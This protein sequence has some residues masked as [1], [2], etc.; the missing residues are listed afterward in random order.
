MTVVDDIKERVDIVEIVG[1][2]VKLRK[3]GKNYVGFCPFHQNT[4][5]P[6]F[7]VFPDTGTWR[8]FGACNEG[9]DVYSFLMKKEGWDFKETLS[10]LA[11]R[12]GI[13]LTPLSP[14]QEA[15]QEAHERL[16]E[17]L[18]AAVVYYRQQLLDSDAGRQVQ[19]YLKGRNLQKP[20]L[21]TFEIGY[22]PDSFELTGRYLSSRGFTEAELEEAGLLS[23]RDSGGTYDR[24]RHRIM[25]PIR[26]SRGRMVGFGARAVDKDAVPKY[27]NSPQTPIFDKSR[28][29]YGLD[30][31]RKA[32]RSENLAV[33]VEG[34]MDVIG[35]H[36][37]GFENLVSPM[38]VALSEHQLRML[39]R[40]SRRMVLALDPDAAGIQGALRGLSVARE[41]LDRELDPVFDARGLLRYEGRLD[42]DI[43][44]VTLPEELDPDEV[45]AQDP[46]EWRRLIDEAKT[47]VDFMMDTLAMEYDLHDPKA[48]G[49]V[50]SRILPLIADVA[51][52]VERDAYRQKLA[53]LLQ[54]DERTLYSQRA[55]GKEKR[56]ARAIL[57]QP[58]GLVSQEDAA[59][60]RFSLGVL[61]QKPEFL[62][63]VDRLF[64]EA[65]LPRLSDEDFQSTARREMFTIIRQSL[66][67]DDMEPGSFW[68]HRLEGAMLELAQTVEA[69]AGDVDFS[70][71]RTRSEILSGF[72]HMRKRRLDARL[73]ELHFQQALA[74]EGAAEDTVHALKPIQDIM[75]Q[76]E[77]LDRALGKQSGRMV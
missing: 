19:A 7:V 41:T 73:Q 25:I 43:R 32:I 51:D 16:R 56:P 59:L 54:V 75:L 33:I 63:H 76:R 26:D 31:A 30:K 8:C 29:L 58:T 2:S 6:S 62:Y 37:A 17:A 20:V 21:E 66:A 36:Q 35:V 15:A 40:Y 4:R 34:Y 24:F 18:E 9:G 68:R 55:S 72:L 49:E 12:T 77:R 70:L 28:L 50:A 1:E 71:P 67:Q 74:Y 46:E 57:V 10:Y 13:V 45:V 5:T 44:I 64:Q 38:G 42:A 11:D 27:L 53:R 22:A 47:V 69:V 23:R 61:L 14:E 48:K 52:P 3:S 60:E 39:K 65:D